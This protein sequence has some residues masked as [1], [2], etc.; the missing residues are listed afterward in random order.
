MRT[1][2]AL[3]F[4][5]FALSGCAAA[6]LELGLEEA[7]IGAVAEEGAAGAAFAPSEVILSENLADTVESSVRSGTRQG[8]LSNA[9]YRLTNGG[10]QAGRFTISSDGG[11]SAA[12]E[13]LATLDANGR[14]LVQGQEVGFVSGEHPWLYEYLRDG[15]T[16][17]IGVL[18]GFTAQNGVQVASQA[19]GAFVRVLRP[20]AAVDVV[21]IADGRYLLRLTDGE[22]VWVD[23]HALQALSLLAIPQFLA[24]CPNDDR[25]GAV[26]R[27]SGELV[28]FAH[29]EKRDGAYVL[30]GADGQTIIDQY[31]VNAILVGDQVP[32]V[33]GDDA[34]QTIV[35]DA[36][37]TASLLG[38]APGQ[39]TVDALG[40]SPDLPALEQVRYGQRSEQAIDALRENLAATGM[41]VWSQAPRQTPW[42]SQR[43]PEQFA[44]ADDGRQSGTS[45]ADRPYEARQDPWRGR[46]PDQ[47]APSARNDDAMRRT[48]AAGPRP[49][50]EPPRDRSFRGAEQQP[51]YAPREGPQRQQTLQRPPQFMQR[52]PQMQYRSAP[53][54][55]GRGGPG[56]R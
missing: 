38:T 17:P 6:A 22:D 15:T 10:Q 29:C 13:R 51:Y 48:D 7:G 20:G 5:T 40:Q 36:Q 41:S 46:A 11:I 42:L 47:T 39:P 21:G 1:T 50:S 4:A 26:M 31:D 49:F 24:G 16:R 30:S 52:Q 14:V 44:R 12:G 28:R 9:F 56:R 32:G 33:P 54:M 43:P 35:S 55:V 3:L 27:K 25:Q 8:E 45:P 18:E 53:P 2:L 19:D 37:A 23:A 34:G